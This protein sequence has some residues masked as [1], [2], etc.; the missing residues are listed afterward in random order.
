MTGAGGGIVTGGGGADSCTGAAYDPASPPATLTLTGNLGAHDPAA[1]V[2]GDT[3]YLAATGLN[4]KTSTNLTM[5]TS[6]GN[7][8]VRPAW[9]TT[10]VPGAT[11][12]WAPDISF[13]G[14]QYHLYY[15]ASTFGSNRSCIGHATRAALDS[16]GWVDT[17]APTICSNVNM[18][19]T[20][21]WNAID[22]NVVIDDAGT[23]WLEFGSFWSGLKLIK[24]DNTGARAD[25]TAPISIAAR[26]RNGGAIE[27]G[28]IF[29]RGARA[30]TAPSITTSGSAARCRS[31]VPTSTRTASR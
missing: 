31:S 27:G 25:T 24:L 15:A 19:T 17:G 21:N 3:I 18:G 14:G 6:T 1:F 7:P 13:F 29:R 26:P 8:L 5:W 16:G 9:V 4:S 22:P 2:A 20:D 30:A 23:P 12:L 10:M 11:N 28:W